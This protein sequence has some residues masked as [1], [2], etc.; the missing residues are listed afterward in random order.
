M[1]YEP[2]LKWK[3]SSIKGLLLLPGVCSFQNQSFQSSDW[4]LCLMLLPETCFLAFFLLSCFSLKLAYTSSR[5]SLTLTIQIAVYKSP[6]TIYLPTEAWLCF[7][8]KEKCK[9]W[10]SYQCPD[11]QKSYT[12]SLV[13]T[14]QKTGF[15]IFEKKFC[16]CGFERAPFLTKILTFL[17][18]LW[19]PHRS[20]AASLVQIP[21]EKLS[22][23]K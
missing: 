13:E 7:P 6:F 23:P 18:G 14:T 12:H 16:T 22:C 10:N 15:L 17:P 3:K 9:R 4:H 11:L 2:E 5:L 21:W 8:W 19:N 20:D 1:A